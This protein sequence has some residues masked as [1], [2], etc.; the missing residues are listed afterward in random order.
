[1]TEHIRLRPGILGFAQKFTINLDKALERVCSM[2]YQDIDKEVARKSASIYIPIAVSVGLL[3]YL[4]AT[5]IGDYPPVARYA[6]SGWVTLLSL[7]VSMPIVTDKVK[8]RR[9]SKV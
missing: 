4:V 6:G 8:K 9:R 3:F 7:I 5:W 2:K 1:M